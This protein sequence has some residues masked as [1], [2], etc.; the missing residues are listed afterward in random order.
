MKALTRTGA[1]AA[2]VGAALLFA[3]GSPAQAP[4]Q[5][6][7]FV[8]IQTRGPIHEA[9]AQPVGLGAQPGV[10]AKQPP[11]PIPE[12]PPDVKPDGDKVEWIGGYWAWDAERNEFIW[13]SGVWRDTPPGRK[14]VAGYWEQSDGGWR[15]VSGYWA[16]VDGAEQPYVPP[17]PANID[18]GP[19]VPPPGDSY[20]YTPGYWVYREGRYVWQPGGYV[21]GQAGRVWVPPYYVWTSSGYLCVGG[22]WDYPLEQRGVLFADVAFGR[23]LWQTPGWSWRPQYAVPATA[24]LD[25]LFVDVRGGHYRYGDY[26]GRAY[27]DAG[28]HPWHAYAAKHH[29][30]LYTHYRRVYRADP[31]WQ[32]ALVKTYDARLAGTAPRPAR[33]FTP[34]ATIVQPATKVVAQK[35]AVVKTNVTTPVVKTVTQPAVQSVVQPVVQQ[36]K[37]EARHDAKV[38]G[39]AVKT[40][41]QPVVQPVVQNKVE[42]RHDVKVTGPAVK[43]V[44]PPAKVTTHVQPAVKTASPPV[45][46][47]QTHAPQQH[48]AVHP[49][50]T[51]KGKTKDH[52]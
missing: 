32:T 1:L 35:Q 46:Q 13:V 11:Q 34:Q 17:P 23:P 24:V 47:V 48:Q 12:Q 21:L 25:S 14:Y 26:Y 43:T 44:T 40:V 39:P 30:P 28:I 22:Y 38:T 42:A 15:W 51:S 2:T 31:T 7:T 20:Q 33:T 8:E 37:V 16:P 29:D 45:R 49:N 19:S 4:V 3:P 41:T 5:Q 36:H 9:F 18:Q 52:K 6:D 10:V 50:N 27:L